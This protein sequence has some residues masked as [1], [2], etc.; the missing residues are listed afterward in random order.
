MKSDSLIYS[1]AFTFPPLPVLQMS[2]DGYLN[3]TDTPGLTG[4]MTFDVN[5]DASQRDLVLSAGVRYSRPDLF[6]ALAVCHTQTSNTSVITL[7]VRLFLF[8]ICFARTASLHFMLFRSC[9]T[10][11]GGTMFWRQI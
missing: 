9:R 2:A 8:L 11:Y 10:T 6:H 3:W 7:Q 5:P 1:L 4:R